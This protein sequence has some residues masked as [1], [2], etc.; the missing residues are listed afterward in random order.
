MAF[1]FSL[2]SVLRLR[3]S[4]EH[5]AELALQDA[6]QRVSTV[7]RQIE[8]VDARLRDDDRRERQRLASGLRAAELHFDGLCRD[9]LLNQRSALQK[10]LARVRHER[11][12]RAAS[13]RQVRQQR[14]TVEALHRR[15]RERY[16]LIAARRQQRELDDLFL[17]LRTHSD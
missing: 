5:Q 1:H 2:E 12:L 13:F 8:E 9:A 4:L 15:Q 10:E 11:D 3:Q 17:L 6:N 14:E 16:E 7:E